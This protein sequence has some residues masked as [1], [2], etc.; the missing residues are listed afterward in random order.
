M[1]IALEATSSFDELVDGDVDTAR[2]V[3]ED[4]DVRFVLEW[5][6]GTVDVVELEHAVQLAKLGLTMGTLWAL[7]KTA[8]PDQP[9]P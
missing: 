5:A 4:G 7:L 9:T 2:I 3:L 8:T 6:N 1:T